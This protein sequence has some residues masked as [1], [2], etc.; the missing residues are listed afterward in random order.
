M[1]GS[2]TIP[3]YQDTVFEYSELTII[4]GEP[5]YDILKL[6]T[7]QLKANSRAVRTTLGGGNHGYLGLVLTPQQY[8]I[9]A[10]GTPFIR[11][12]HPGPL[13]I[14]LYQLPHVTQQAQSHH[15]EQVR[16][17]NEC[18]NVEQAL[19]R[20][21]ISAVQDSYLTALKNH[22]TNTITTPLNQV[23][24]YLFRNY[25]RVTPTQ[26]IHE[27]Q[28]LTTWNY[29]TTMPIVIVFNK[30]DDLM[31][32]ASAAGPPYSTQQIINFAYLT[33]NKTGKFSQGIWEWNRLQ[34]A[35]K[36]WDT[37]Q[38]HFTNEYQALRD[39]GELH[40]QHSTYQTANIV[41]EVVNGVQ[42]AL[43]PTPEDIDEA[44]ELLHQANLSTANASQQTELLQQMI[45]MMQ[46]MQSQLA[47]NI[48]APASVPSQSANIRTRHNTSK[49]CWTHGACAHTGRDCRLKKEGHD[50]MATF[51]N[52]KGGSTAY[53]C[54]V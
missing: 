10:P 8:D 49:Y 18:F 39:P 23:L 33:L 15:S 35:Q 4:H 30:V 54:N 16:L 26:L 43:N 3:N 22:Q 44:P 7:N 13:V 34:P 38:T 12:V 46:T 51:Q 53:V 36:I 48:T 28:Q 1:S 21:V 2:S 24:E 31:D 45:Q 20:Q 25:R 41:Q 9:V 27:E 37:F 14:S 47:S 42:Q 19:R 17:Y 29:D 11:P 32:L 50:D 40:A 6:L 5:T 52:R